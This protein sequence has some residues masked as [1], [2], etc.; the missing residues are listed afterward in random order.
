MLFMPNKFLIK[1]GNVIL[2][3][4]REILDSL[5]CAH[6]R[7]TAPTKFLTSILPMVYVMRH[8]YSR[9]AMHFGPG[10]QICF[11]KCRCLAWLLS[12]IMM[13]FRYD[14]YR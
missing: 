8:M 7:K 4:M 14:Q 11:K 1:R 9:F 12:S 2:W 3:N 10:F 6:I 13:C 5:R